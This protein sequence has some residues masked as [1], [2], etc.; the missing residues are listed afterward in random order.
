MTSSLHG[1]GYWS[2]YENRT[3]LDVLQPLYDEG[4]VVPGR[5]GRRSATRPPVHDL[6][7]RELRSTL[8]VGTEHWLETLYRKPQIKVG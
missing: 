1:Y 7:I 6:V 8:H 3:L 2:E 5:T 4:R